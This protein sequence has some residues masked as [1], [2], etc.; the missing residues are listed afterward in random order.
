MV[1]GFITALIAS[2][3]ITLVV[4]IILK[5]KGPWGT[6]WSLFVF[7]FLALWT[8]SLYIRAMGP[9]YLGVSWL[10]VVFAGLLLT[11]LLL[12]LPT[13]AANEAVADSAP[14]RS[15]NK[16]FWILLAIFIFAIIIGMF[17]PQL[18]L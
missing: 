4:V 14:S 3:I 18:A 5:S 9:S 2:V 15:A 6:A 8:V 7:L 10:P 16:F 12:S 17:N 1:S 11:I 13:T